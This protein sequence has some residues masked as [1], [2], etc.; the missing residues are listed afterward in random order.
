VARDARRVAESTRL[1]SRRDTHQ[2]AGSP[3][4]PDAHHALLPA[5]L[6]NNQAFRVAELLYRTKC[7]PAFYVMAMTPKLLASLAASVMF[8][9]LTTAP[10]E[11]QR[12]RAPGSGGA[13]GGRAAPPSGGARPPATGRAV[14]RGSMPG[15]ARPGPFR[16]RPYIGPRY[17]LG[18]G[19][20]YGSYF[21]FGLGYPYY[22][23]GYGYDY[24][25]GYG[26]GL[27]YPYP[28][29]YG[30][31]AYGYPDS[32]S[33]YGYGRTYGDV[34]IVDAPKDAE[35]YVDG[36]Y[37]GVVDDVDGTFQ[38]LSLEPGPHRIEI[39]AAGF[40]TA[41]YDVNADISRTITIHARM[42]AAQP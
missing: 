13:S 3:A 40:E 17:G 29:P 25:L 7:Q 10:A 27:G 21:G 18:F 30:Y 37:E 41:T 24:G 2:G 12:S 5:T 33:G 1:V 4:Q 31:P 14:P 39:R 20:P 9:V 42:R 15:I 32:Y 16:V 34:R 36:Y 38:H 11:A 23:Y 22:G 26:Y 19:Y 35:I 28:Y 6:A 8:F